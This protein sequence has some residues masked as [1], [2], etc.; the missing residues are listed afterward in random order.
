[1]N[2]VFQSLVNIPAP[3]KMV[4]MIVL[5]CCAAG[6]ISS[7]AKQVRKF[8]TH[9]QELEFK[10]ELVDRGMSAE[11]IERIVAAKGSFT[12]KDSA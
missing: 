9:Q 12:G 2:D 7:V 10:R 4:V 8:G 3:F 1:M 11:E 5:I 6:I